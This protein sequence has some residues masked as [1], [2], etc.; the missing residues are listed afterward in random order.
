MFG[1]G[2]TRI[3][4]RFLAGDAVALTVHEK[5]TDFPEV[6]TFEE[7]L[8]DKLP[9]GMPLRAYRMWS[10]PS[11]VDK[12]FVLPAKTPMPTVEA[13][14]E[15]FRKVLDDPEF[16]RYARNVLGEGYV[17]LTGPA[18]RDLVRDSIVVPDE[19]QEFNKKLRAKHGLPLPN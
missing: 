9:K 18:T 16:Q 7:Y 15:S 12:Y 8:G 10:G 1:S 2:T 14:R 4:E 11:A 13:L 17:P 19:I 3:I 5:R 6:P